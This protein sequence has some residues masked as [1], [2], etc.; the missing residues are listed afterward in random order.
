MKTFG[1]HDMALDQGM[2]G[3]QRR[4]T[5]ADMIGQRRQGQIDALATVALALTVQRL[6]LPELL[7]QHHRQQVRVGMAARDDVE[8]RRRL[9]DRLAFPAG[10]ALAHRL[11][12][13]PLARNH[14]Q[15]LRDILAELHQ[16]P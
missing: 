12:H 10:E 1:H 4:G 11:D 14:L 5:G 9:G 7:E 16:P 15:R 6:V 3:P 2:E 8:R 13:F